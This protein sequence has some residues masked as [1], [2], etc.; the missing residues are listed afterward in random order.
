VW[1]VEAS[2]GAGVGPG[3][4][5]L[6]A[7]PEA[8]WLTAPGAAG[9]LDG[10]VDARRFLGGTTLYAVRTAAGD[11]LDVSAPLHAAT[12]GSRVGVVPSRRAGGGIHLF[13]VRD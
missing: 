1:D 13:A 7:R 10:V 12:A 8:L 9:A 6:V 11:V 4:V 5:R 3:P 2:A